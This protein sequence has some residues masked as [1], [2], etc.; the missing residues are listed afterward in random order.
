V[1]K[2]VLN[3]TISK[4]LL[5]AS[6]VTFILLYPAIALAQG[7]AEPTALDRLSTEVLNVLIPVFVA[8]IGGLA[9]WLLSKMQKKLGIEIG[10]K[11]HDAWSS[12]ARKGA[13]RAAEWARNKAKDLAEGKKIPGPEILEVGANW[14]IDMGKAYKLPEIGRAKLEGLIEAELFQLRREEDGTETSAPI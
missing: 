1:N 11:A 6:V 4:L 10:D 8:F 14:A 9:T 13:L 12:L 5:L 7:T 2:L 3:K